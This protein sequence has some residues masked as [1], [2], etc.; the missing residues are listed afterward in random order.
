[1]S[2]FGDTFSNTGAMALLN[3]NPKTKDLNTSVKTLF[4]SVCAASFRIILMPIGKYS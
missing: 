2:R 4:S 1:L 3:S